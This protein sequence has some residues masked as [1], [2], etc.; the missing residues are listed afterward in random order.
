MKLTC[1]KDKALTDVM[2]AGAK[3][4][5]AWLSAYGKP[6]LPFERVYREATNFQK[7]RPDEHM[8]S[9]QDYVR[10]ASHIIP[11]EDWLHKPTLRH[12]DLQPNNILVSDNHEIV[13]LIDW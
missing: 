3:K 11:E 13:G 1:P 12:S 4:E 10:I 9:L 7:S 6:R 8:Q 5:M 2:C